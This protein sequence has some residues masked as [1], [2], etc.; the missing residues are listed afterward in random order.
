MPLVAIAWTMVAGA[1]L[2][3]AIGPHLQNATFEAYKSAG[4]AAGVILSLAGHLFTQGRA[5]RDLAEKDSKFYLDSA[6]LALEEARK[7]LEDGNNDRVTWIAA[8]R[9]LMQAQNLAD[10]VST[11]AHKKVLELHKLKYRSVFRSAITN[12]PASFYYGAED[13]TVPIDKAAEDST[14]PTTSA[15][16]RR[17]SSTLKSLPET[18]LYAVWKACQWPVDYQ[19]PLQ[20]PFPKEELGKLLAL[21]PE[22][23]EYLEHT[24]KWH[25]ASGKLYPREA[26]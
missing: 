6:V 3:V 1:I 4:V 16:G 15:G 5:S 13:P 14:A 2:L 25:S 9:A 11:D 24:H 10:M 12:K 23:Y 26:P 17:V 8:G 7:L 22:L 20:G 18:A 21:Y 19:D